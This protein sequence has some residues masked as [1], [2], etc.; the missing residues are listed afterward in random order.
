MRHS[1]PSR[2]IRV[3]PELA[4]VRRSTVG[5]ISQ[6]VEFFGKLQKNFVVL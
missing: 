2:T 4:E 1:C 3:G 6:A 5:P